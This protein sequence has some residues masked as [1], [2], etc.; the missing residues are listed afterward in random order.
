M[1]HIIEFYSKRRAAQCTEDASKY[2]DG[3]KDDLCLDPIDSEKVLFVVQNTGAAEHLYRSAS[4]VSSL[5]SSFVRFLKAHV[6]GR[7]GGWTI[8]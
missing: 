8:M 3:L 1:W 6:N 5:S 2:H 7:S 4:K